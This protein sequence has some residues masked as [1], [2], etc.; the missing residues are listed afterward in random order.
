[1][2]PL[3]D[4]RRFKTKENFKLGFM[5]TCERWSQKGKF[6]QKLV[7]PLDMHDTR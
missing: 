2:Y 4:Y 3:L 7:S 6:D 5:V 1:M